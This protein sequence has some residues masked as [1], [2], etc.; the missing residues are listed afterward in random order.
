MDCPDE[1]A[2]HTRD[3]ARDTPEEPPTHTHTKAEVQDTSPALHS[4]DSKPHLKR[5]MK[6]TEAKRKE[7]R[8]LQTC[9]KERAASR[10][11]RAGG[12]GPPA[13]GRA[14]C[15]RWHVAVIMCTVLVARNLN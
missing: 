14:A 9:L 11:S 13:L 7:Q 4:V 12:L 6:C 2:A 8:P 3:K 1:P 15:L 5:R 10:G